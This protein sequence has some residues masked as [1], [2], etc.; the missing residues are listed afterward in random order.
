[1]FIFSNSLTLYSYYVGGAEYNY[2]IYFYFPGETFGF[3][4]LGFLFILIS[5]IIIFRFSV[6]RV[7]LYRGLGMSILGGVTIYGLIKIDIVYHGRYLLLIYLI[8][9]LITFIVL[10]STRRSL[11][12]AT[13]NE[14]REY[15]KKAARINQSISINK[16]VRYIRIS[17]NYT[18]KLK[19]FIEEMISN[20]EILGNLKGNSLHFT[21]QM[22]DRTSSRISEKPADIEVDY[23][24]RLFGM[25]RLRKEI[26]LEE[27][28]QF[29]NIPPKQIESLLYDLAGEKI[30]QGKFQGNRFLIESDMDNF[31]K[32]LDYSF[33]KWETD[34]REKV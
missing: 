28:S 23:K 1:M 8:W 24:K 12:E 30:I 11:I 15:I 32:A 14:T 18:P 5:I 2:M 16:I 6:S 27:A 25:I 19:E 33:N 7:L 21:Q 31:L 20:K 9:F 34:E 13:E 10:A 22:D 4:Y 3:G 17:K 26:N 29:L